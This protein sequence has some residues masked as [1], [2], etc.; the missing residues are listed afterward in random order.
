[1]LQ[2]AIS[3]SIA[4]ENGGPPMT[5]VAASRAFGYLSNAGGANLPKLQ[6]VTQN[7]L[8]HSV[9]YDNAGNETAYFMT[10]TYSPRNLLAS[11]Q[12]SWEISSAHKILYAYDG[13]GVRVQKSETPTGY[14]TSMA[15]RDYIYAPELHLLSVSRPNN[16]TIYGKR[17]IVANDVLNAQYDIVWF[18]G[19]PV[20]HIDYDSGT[21]R[22]TYTDHLGTPIMQV[23]NS[24][25]ILWQADYEPFG[26]VWQMRIGGAADQPLRFPGQER[27]MD[28][29]GS[30]ENYNIFRWYR[31]SWGRYT[32]VD[33]VGV[34]VSVNLY[35][36]AGN[37]PLTTFDPTGE[38]II[39]VTKV[40]EQTYQTLAAYQGA[41]PCHT[42]G[43]S[44]S[45]T[46]RLREQ[47]NCTCKCVAK[48]TFAMDVEITIL[49]RYHLAGGPPGAHLPVSWFW[50]K[51][52]AHEDLHQSDLR[53]ELLRYADGLE[54]NRYASIVDCNKDCGA[55]IVG[56]RD[57]M[58]HW[59]V[60]SNRRLH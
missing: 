59:A 53:A 54:S 57:W 47:L 52:R 35:D 14:T 9:T 24:G 48:D 45:C 29:E 1:M 25:T 43:P 12:D 6:T 4:G 23:D 56:L 58:N 10:R 51:Y 8:D 46:E 17:A 15:T 49:L 50:N 28:W 3:R 11:V 19:V 22:S 33:P 31:A 5:F 60:D 38:A 44:Y 30:D 21:T 2:S 40:G 16:P 13:R 27:A 34:A 18:G 37:N 7:G 41:N 39:N 55:A 42:S 36:Y 20:A 32:Q 26:N